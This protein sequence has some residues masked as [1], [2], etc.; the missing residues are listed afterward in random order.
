MSAHVVKNRVTRTT[1]ALNAKVEGLFVPSK[2]LSDT[3]TNNVSSRKVVD[4]Q[5]EFWCLDDQV[6]Y[7]N[8]QLS[9][10]SLQSLIGEE[11]LTNADANQGGSKNYPYP[12]LLLTLE[13]CRPTVL[14]PLPTLGMHTTSPLIVDNWRQALRNHPDRR[15]V[16]YLL[17]GLTKGFHI[18]FNPT[19]HCIP[20][21]ENMKSAH[22]NPQPVNEYLLTEL[23]AGRI[24]G[25][26]EPHLLQGAQVSCFGVI[27]KANQSGKWRLILDLSSPVNQSVNDG[28]SKHL[29]S[30]KY[31][32][33]DDAIE[34]ILD[35]GANVT[36]SLSKEFVTS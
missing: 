2:S 20:C 12:E 5:Q 25:P 11:I 35:M 30:M 16:Q 27:P 9:T 33:T 28:I 13:A 17:E 29:C 10:D 1:S 22:E 14:R 4:N 6:S 3:A 23:A 15:F 7:P 24:V 32:T 18:G 19:Q 36:W 8:G 26:F 31:A 21:K 34:K